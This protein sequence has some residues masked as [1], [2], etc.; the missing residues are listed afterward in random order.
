M[1]LTTRVAL[2][3]TVALLC[4]VWAF[5]WHQASTLQSGLQRLLFDQQYARVQYIANSLDEALKAR[6]H[7]LRVLAD[8]VGPDELRHPGKVQALL[9]AQ[10]PLGRIFD[11]GLYVIAGDGRGVADFPIMPGRASADYTQREYFRQVLATGRPVVGKPV[12]GR[13]AKEPVLLIAV[14]IPGQDGQVAG[15]LVGANRV[16]GSDLFNE[17]QA[18]DSGRNG[19]T[20]ILSVE[21]RIFVAS[22]DPARVLTP[23]ADRGVNRLLDRYLDGYEGSGIMLNSRGIEALSSASHVATAGWIVE[24]F[25]PT[26]IAFALVRSQRQEIYQDAAL[27]SLFMALAVGLFLWLQLAPLRKAAALLRQM[28]D[29]RLTLRTIP[30]EGSPELRQLFHGFNQLHLR[31]SEQELGRRQAEEEKDRLQEQL[32]QAQKMESIGTLAGGIAHDFNN[33]LTAILGY[34]NLSLMDLAEGDPRRQN[35]EL[36]LEAGGRAA[37]LTKDLLLFSRRQV[38]QRQT[39]DLNEVVR[40]TE[41]FLRRVIGEDVQFRTSL[42]PLPI[43]VL[44]DAH[45]LEQVLMNLAANGRDAMAKGGILS[46]STEMV[47]LDAEY[48]ALHGQGPPGRY[49]QLTFSDTGAGMDAETR[50]R[51]FEPF[52]TT[53]GVGKGTGLGLAVVYGIVQQHGGHITVYSEPDRGTTF[54]ILLPLSE[55]QVVQANAAPE[56]RPQGGTETILLAE[57]DPTVR[58]LTSAVLT[59]FGYRVLLAENGQEAVERWRAHRDEID[60][61]LFDVIMPGKT[62]KDAHAEIKALA[63]EVKVIFLSGYAPD[64]LWQEAAQDGGAVMASKPIAPTALLRLVREVLDGRPGRARLPA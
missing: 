11:L 26:S 2:F 5:A 34:G 20:H 30:V 47:E 64:V 41:Q 18:P 32:L 63:P 31:L 60:L 13:F 27:L 49:A 61:L 56:A 19:D 28:A 12:S 52:F 58:S 10:R 29:E 21:H 14:P 35:L 7:A 39:V 59:R 50:R 44:A 16:H 24:N 48:Q 40:G 4:A 23:L 25:L 8:G 54:R 55:A 43:P 17:I 22:S 62:G 3:I 1:G 46:V 42:A 45:Q 51:I 6:V 57:D 15:V 9:E 36:L 33:I 53:K 38:G 37:M